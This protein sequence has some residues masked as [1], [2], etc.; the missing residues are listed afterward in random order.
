MI[1]LDDVSNKEE[2]VQKMTQKCEEIGESRGS[3]VKSCKLRRGL[4]A[5]RSIVFKGIASTVKFKFK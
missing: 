4:V 1:L 3:A 5:E 2:V